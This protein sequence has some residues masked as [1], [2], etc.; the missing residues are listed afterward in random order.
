MSREIPCFIKNRGCVN[1]ESS[2]ALKKKTGKEF[3]F[4]PELMV[5]CLIRH[6]SSYSLLE[7]YYDP[8]QIVQ[9]A[10]KIGTPEVKEK[11]REIC[12]ILQSQFGGF[13]ENENI[14]IGDI[15]KKLEP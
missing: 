2:L 6:S 4:D 12:S 13:Y 15:L 1:C 3:G 7:P 8:E 11:A 14:S 5:G 9:Y 10:S